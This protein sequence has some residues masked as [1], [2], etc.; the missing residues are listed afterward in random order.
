[1]GQG[2]GL[3]G[4]EAFLLSES[5]ERFSAAAAVAAT[6]RDRSSVGLCGGKETMR[7]RIVA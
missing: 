5:Y 3:K 6:G 1:M 7:R 2:G 4:I